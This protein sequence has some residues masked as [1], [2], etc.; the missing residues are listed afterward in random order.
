MVKVNNPL[1]LRGT[2]ILKFTGAPD[3]LYQNGI[4]SDQSI[5]I[6][7]PR[8]KLLSENITE[9]FCL[10]INFRNNMNFLISIKSCN[11]Y[12]KNID[13]TWTLFDHSLSNRYLIKN[14]IHLQIR[15]SFCVDD[16]NVL[17]PESYELILILDNNQ[18]TKM[19]FSDLPSVQNQ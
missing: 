11:A 3:M 5:S 2:L 13:N 4:I 15:G 1:D 17:G 6:S 16:A 14:D 10:S 7:M 8:K 18:I 19:L 12:F 9:E